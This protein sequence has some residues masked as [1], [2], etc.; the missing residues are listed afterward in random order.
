VISVR[1]RPEPGTGGPR[2]ERQALVFFM[3]DQL[4]NAADEAASA[5]A[6]P[7]N[8]NGELLLQMEA[9]VRRLQ[10]QLQSTLE[11]YD[12]STEEMKSTNEELQSIN[13]E[14]RSTTEEL[15]TSKEE[16]QSV[17]EELLTVNHELKEKLE[18]ISRAHSDLENLIASTEVATLF[19]DRELRIQRFT[20]GAHAVFNIL[21]TDHGR[22]IGHLTHNLSYGSL[23]EDAQNVLRSLTPLAREVEAA[24]GQW[25]LLRLRPYKTLDDRIEGVVITFVEITRLKQAERALRELNES[26][27][28]RVEQRTRELDETNQ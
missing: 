24:Q 14:F 9:E 23:I 26:L 18:E 4:T 2:Q 11:E 21:D 17:N 19:L 3:E 1:I 15:E 16:L 25:Y 13:E 28:R 12:S 5:P 6:V 10:E 20:P 27:E 22:P 8:R 7:A